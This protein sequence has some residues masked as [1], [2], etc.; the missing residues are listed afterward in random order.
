M[1]TLRFEANY[2]QHG[3]LTRVELPDGSVSGGLLVRGDR[4]VLVLFEELA[5]ETG[6]VVVAARDR[7]LTVAS[8]HHGQLNGEPVTALEV[9][10]QERG[11]GG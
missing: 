11:S 5:L 6:D 3:A 7:R 1:S 8:V 2:R 10:A 9:E 4:P